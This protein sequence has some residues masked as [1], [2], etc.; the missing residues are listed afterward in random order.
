MLRREEPHLLVLQ[1]FRAHSSGL[2]I[3]DNDRRYVQY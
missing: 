1:L 3:R 2:S